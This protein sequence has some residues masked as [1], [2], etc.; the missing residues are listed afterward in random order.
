MRGR[1]HPASSAART[2][3]SS[4]SARNRLRTSRPSVVHPTRERMTVIAKKTRIGVQS[5]GRAAVSASQIGM[6][7]SDWSSSIRRWITRSGS[8]PKYPETPPSSTPSTTLSVTATRPMVID[9]WVP[10]MSRD[11]WSRPRRSV[12]RRWTRPVVLPSAAPSRWRLG[13]NRPSTRYGYPR[14]RKRTRTFWAG[15]TCHSMRSVV[16]LRFPTTAGTQGLHRMPSNMRA[17]AA[18]G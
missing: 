4:R 15:S 1:P 6:V 3:S 13:G 2:K 12:P 9:V 16:G 5:R 17:D 11:H 7:G 10:C 8:P 14:T 18:P